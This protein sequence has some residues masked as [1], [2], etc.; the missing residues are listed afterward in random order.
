[1]TRVS[2]ARAVAKIMSR[3]R[4]KRGRDELLAYVDDM[5]RV[6]RGIVLVLVG[7][8]CMEFTCQERLIVRANIKER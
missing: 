2:G 5:R 3:S 7:I 6:F 4:D 1:M 8:L